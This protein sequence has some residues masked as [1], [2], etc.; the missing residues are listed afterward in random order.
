MTVPSLSSRRLLASSL[1]ELHARYNSW[2]RVHDLHFPT[3][4]RGT[5][6]TIAKSGGANIPRKHWRALGLLEPDEATAYGRT[7][8]RTFTRLL[9]EFYG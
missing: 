9:K 1:Q 3:I 6:C 5:L 8:K 7:W 4:P 2:S